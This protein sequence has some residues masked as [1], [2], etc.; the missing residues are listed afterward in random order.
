M[1]WKIKVEPFADKN[2]EKLDHSTR[3]KIKEYLKQKVLATGNPRSK[4]KALSGNMRGLWRY[5][6][7]KY[8]IICRI[9]DSVLTVIVI[10][11]GKRDE[12]YN[13]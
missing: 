6:V 4:G 7:G 10:E 3:K 13:D 5:R 12:V 9:R 2:L 11:I 1:V 8:R